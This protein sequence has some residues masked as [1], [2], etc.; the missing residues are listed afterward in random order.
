MSRF[1]KLTETFILLEMVAVKEQ[2]VAVEVYPLVREKADVI[3]PEA[4]WFVERAHYVPFLSWR[5]LR[6]N[7]QFLRRK[8]RLF[9]ST[10]RHLLTGTW[11]SKRYF[12]RAL[13]LFPKSVYFAAHM[14][15]A[16]ITHVHAHF[17]SHP[18]AAAYVIH[19]LTGIPFS[20]T[21]HGSDIHRDRTMLAEKVAAARFVVPISDFNKRVILDACAGQFA[22]KM[23]VI[24]CGVDTKQFRPLCQNGNQSG[25]EAGAES[26]LL[27]LC[28]IGTLHEVKGQRFL[29]EAC[30]LLA[31]RNLNVHCHFVGDGPDKAA[32]MRQSAEAGLSGHITFHGQQTRAEVAKLLQT[33]DIVVA[34]SVPSS[35]GRREGIPVALMEAM[36]TGL[37]V[38]ASRLSG[39]PELV[40]DGVNGL[41]TP[42]GDAVSLAN[43][44]ERLRLDPALRRRLGRAGRQK[45]LEDFDLDKNAM[46]L[47]QRF[48]G[49]VPS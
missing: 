39:I 30:R 40:D 44:L 34:P 18:A 11:R 23:V 47:A 27:T 16:E 12:T 17:A 36:A 45:V 33:T 8:P 26:N 4:E 42:P 46:L 6:A 43:A 28:S 14:E 1:P 29:I 35:D 19:R 31:E 32:L 13:A 22:E 10:L 38:V 49:E 3:H 20:F 25:V 9:F 21:A 2:G 5:V 15:A 7:L 37:P 41:L 48:N 24:H